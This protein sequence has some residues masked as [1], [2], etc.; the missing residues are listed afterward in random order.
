MCA[1]GMH[2]CVCVCGWV[3]AQCL[4]MASMHVRVYVCLCMCV[5]LWMGGCTVYAHVGDF[6]G[7]ALISNRLVLAPQ[8]QCLRLTSHAKRT[9]LYRTHAHARI[10]FAHMH[11]RMCKATTHS[12][13]HSHTYIRTFTRTL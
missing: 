2:V 6:E 5:C 10:V 13:T 4:R 7:H 11:T 3:G 8:C 9:L 12:H 1:Y